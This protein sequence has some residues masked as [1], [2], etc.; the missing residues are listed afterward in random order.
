MKKISLVAALVAGALFSLIAT[1]AFADDMDGWKKAVVA[2]LVK[3]QKYPRSAQ[4][5]GIEGKA[6]VRLVVSADGSITAHEILE[7]TGED[8]L[9]NEIPKLVA[10]LNPLPALPAGQGDLSFILP[11]EWSLR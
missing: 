9:D 7:S 1:P 4:V 6:K 10:K 11:L 5:R 2:K 3:N 8:V